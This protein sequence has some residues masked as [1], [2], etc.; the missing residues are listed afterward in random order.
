M[1]RRSRVLCVVVMGVLAMLPGCTEEGASAP[2][3]PPGSSAEA[4]PLLPDGWRWESYRDIAVGVPGGWGYGGYGRWSDWCADGVGKEPVV[5]RPG[6]TFSIACN[7]DPRRPKTGVDPGALVKNTGA[8]VAFLAGTEDDVAEEG[9]REIVRAGTSAVL[10]QAEPNL[11]TQIARTVHVLAD[12]DHNECPLTHPIS[13]DPTWRPTQIDRAAVA[14]PEAISVC[15]FGLRGRHSGPPA[16]PTLI[17][18]NRILGTAAAAAIEAI[19]SAPEGGGPNR[20]DPRRCDL[21]DGYGD[22][23]YILRISRSR[24]LAAEIVVHYAGCNHNGFDDGDTL[25]T[26]TA[27]GLAPLIRQPNAPN[28]YI[29]DLGMPGL[30][31]RAK[32]LNDETPD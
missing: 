20:T 8:F 5:G 9:D 11:R 13:G 32:K 24:Q 17:S 12:R 18:S 27:E 1:S 31:A 25:R 10:V 22:E 26:L 2:D 29:G 7:G 30:M 16:G 6:G 28:G 23:V 3:V 14:E 21:D 4:V 15:K 19:F